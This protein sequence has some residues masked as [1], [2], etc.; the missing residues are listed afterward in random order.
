MKMLA[1]LNINGQRILNS[2][3][4]RINVFSCVFE[5]I[6]GVLIFNN[7]QKVWPMIVQ[8]YI[9]DVIII[10]PLLGAQFSRH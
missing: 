6:S 5:Q 8:G 3:L 10:E 7:K 9:S 1:P 4:Y 2:N